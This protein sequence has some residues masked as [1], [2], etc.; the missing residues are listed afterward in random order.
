[1][2]FLL[3]VALWILSVCL[4]EYAHARVAFAGGDTSVREK[5]YLSLN[6]L[7]YTDPM[8]SVVFP[9]VFL[10]LGGIGLPGGA[11]YIERWRLRGPGWESAV[12]LA[13]PAAN[14]VLAGAVGVLVG[15]AP[16][17]GELR[18]ALAFVGMLQ[19]C[20][21]LLNLIPIPPLDGYGA[22]APFLAP[23]TRKAAA[24]A[25]RWSIF[26]LFLA[27]WLVE[28]VGQAFWEAV[29]GVTG[30]LGIPADLAFRGYLDFR[31]SMNL[32]MR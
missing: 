20:A 28:P 4:H 19:V 16:A 5:G 29:V 1:M 6:P 14:L 18:P 23:K 21:V 26:V 8:L 7:R 2:A 25:G 10:L 30:A 15:L 13:G 17:G 32:V 31:D 22:I 3:V 11:V 12:S 9:V 24:R 27:L